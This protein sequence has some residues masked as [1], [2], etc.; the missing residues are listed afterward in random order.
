MTNTNFKRIKR[1]II[2]LAV[3]M[4]T[5]IGSV[6]PATQTVQAAVYQSSI[7]YDGEGEL[8]KTLTTG[9]KAAISVSDS[10]IMEKSMDITIPSAWEHVR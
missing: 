4:A 1:N 2:A 9:Q 6:A 5:I 8:T 7:I 3:A 10:I